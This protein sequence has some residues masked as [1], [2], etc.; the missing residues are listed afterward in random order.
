MAR[1]L[2]RYL[3]PEF[4]ARKNSADRARYQPHPR[5]PRTDQQIK[6]RAARMRICNARVSIKHHQERA[7]FFIK[8]ILADRK[9]IEKL[10]KNNP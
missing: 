10:L 8:R 7:A 5:P 4:K 3:D 1:T 6:I 2:S 9:L